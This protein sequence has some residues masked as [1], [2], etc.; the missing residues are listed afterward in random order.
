MSRDRIWIEG[1]RAINFVFGGNQIPFSKRET[2]Q[3]QMKAGLVACGEAAEPLFG[4]IKLLLSARCLGQKQHRFI[5]VWGSV[6]NCEGLFSRFRKLSHRHENQ[7]QF[8]PGFEVVGSQIPCFQ[9]KRSGVQ[10]RALFEPDDAQSPDC[11]GILRIGSE[12]IQVFN[13]C[14]IV[15]AGLEIAVGPIQEGGTFSLRRSSRWQQ[16]S[17]RMAARTRGKIPFSVGIHLLRQNVAEFA[18]ERTSR[19]GRGRRSGKEGSE[20]IPGPG[21]RAQSR[22]HCR[23]SIYLGPQAKSFSWKFPVFQSTHRASGG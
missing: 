13:L 1:K 14:L 5:V 15:L 10:R 21:A 12:H 3:C 4:V 9:E 16:P 20:V 6:E 11:D 7:G 17:T 8:R 2:G 23:I 19:N 18:G 22:S